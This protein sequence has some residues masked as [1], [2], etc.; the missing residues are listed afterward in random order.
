[1]HRFRWLNDVPLNDTHFDESVHFLE[2][3]ENRPDGTSIRWTW[4]S[5]LELNERSVMPIMRAVRSRWRI[6]NENFQTLKKMTGYN[7]EHNFGHGKNSLCNVFAMLAVLGFLMDQV[8][9][10]CCLLFQKALIYHKRKSYLWEDIRTFFKR[11][12][13]ND[14]RTFWEMLSRPPPKYYADHADICT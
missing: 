2:Y 3:R 4:V 1:M 13:F 8:Q 10:L 9:E 6:E 12:G 7:L 5:D 11:V 14:W